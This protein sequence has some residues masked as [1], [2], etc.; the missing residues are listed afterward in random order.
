MKSIKELAKVTDP[1]VARA[2]GM[3]RRMVVT[4]SGAKAIWQLTGFRQLNGTDEVVN[5]EVFTG[6]GVFARP[7]GAAEAIVVMV[8]DGK[9]PAVVAVRD[10]KTRSAIAGNLK[11]DETALY[12]SQAI[13]HITDSG[14]IEARTASGTAFGLALKS[15]VEA[16]K[17]VFDEHG[18]TSAAAGTPTSKPGTLAVGTLNGASAPLTTATMP[19]PVGTTVLKGE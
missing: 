7:P 14:K 18:H 3:I 4:L 5:A 16:Q 6:I 13:L 10:E 8:G 11:A 2:A 12:N 1:A 9:V 19:A 15:D 17:A